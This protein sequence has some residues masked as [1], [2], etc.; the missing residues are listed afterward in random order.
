MI[1]GPGSSVALSYLYYL[2]KDWNFYGHL[3]TS[4]FAAPFGLYQEDIKMG[5]V[6]MG[7]TL[8][9]PPEECTFLLI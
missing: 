7:D 1:F 5:S 4:Y 6:G 2:S 9:T 3:V 8:C